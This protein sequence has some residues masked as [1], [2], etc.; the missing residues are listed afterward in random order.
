M[1][2]RSSICLR[3]RAWPITSRRAGIELQGGARGMGAAYTKAFLA[4]GAKVGLVEWDAATGAA[5]GA[6]LLRA[7]GRVRQ[8]AFAES[9][10][11]HVRTRT[12]DGRLFANGFGSGQTFIFDMS[13]LEGVPYLQLCENR[14]YETLTSPDSVN[15]TAFDSRFS[16]I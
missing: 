10:C 5:S 13:E 8:I 11:D 16:M 7:I 9:D 6:E 12:N 1:V 15:F 4:V 2:N 3:G 14:P